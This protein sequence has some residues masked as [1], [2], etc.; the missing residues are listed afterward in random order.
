MRGF[1]AEALAT[2][3]LCVV[4]SETGSKIDGY[5]LGEG[6]SKITCGKSENNI[7]R[8]RREARPRWH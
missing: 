4:A 1:F 8:S 7:C 6:E 5:L 2:A 3:F